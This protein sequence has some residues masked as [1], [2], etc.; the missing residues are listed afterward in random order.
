M[1]IAEIFKKTYLFNGI[2]DANLKKIAS[3]A[4][5]KSFKKGEVI[6]DE[7]SEGD[8]IL[9]VV[10]GAAEIFC[11]SASG[12][13]KIKLANILPGDYFGEMALLEV[14]PRSASVLAKEQTDVIMIFNDD[15]NKLLSSDNG[16][17]FVPIVV[18]IARGM[19]EKLRR[20]NELIS[21]IQCSIQKYQGIKNN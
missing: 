11:A 9:L 15:L 13:Q 2:S 5:S 12:E 19:S 4:K 21:Q 1:N 16:L 14:T 18:N 8:S 7:G 17:E 10:K 6:I 3:I 20:A